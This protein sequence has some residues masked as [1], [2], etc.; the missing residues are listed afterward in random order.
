M[1]YFFLIATLVY[2][3][4]DTL[5]FMEDDSV[6]ERW[7]VNEYVQ[8]VDSGNQ[9][10][11]VTRKAKVAS[12]NRFF[13]IC[14]DRLGPNFEY[15]ESKIVIYNAEKKELWK[16]TVTDSRKISL[17]LSNVYDSL[18]II[19]VLDANGRNP[20][21][22]LIRDSREY[23]IVK[24]PDWMR[25][26]SYQ[27]SPNYRFLVLHVRKRYFNKPWDYVYSID[28]N[29]EKEWQYVFPTCLS[30]KRTKISLGIDNKGQVEVVH[31]AEHRIFSK[32]GELIDYFVKID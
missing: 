28:F 21:L 8:P 23:K 1:V 15:L 14:E 9:G 31:R 2:Q 20:E 4:G 17:D 24:N 3:H 27:I 7:V 10:E 30:C 25:L 18:F 26:F 22:R 11:K 19:A 16:E 6:T 12:S 32:D 13:F 5:L 29:T